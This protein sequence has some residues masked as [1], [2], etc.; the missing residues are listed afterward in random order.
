MKQELFLLCN[1]EDYMDGYDVF[2]GVMVFD[3]NGIRDWFSNAIKE[4]IVCEDVLKEHS[5]T[6][7]VNV[8]E[9][10]LCDVMEI[11][12]DTGYDIKLIEVNIEA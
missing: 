3:E 11:I 2:D 4:E 9:L 8:G 12:Q 10:E 6:K 1:I 7:D 5:L